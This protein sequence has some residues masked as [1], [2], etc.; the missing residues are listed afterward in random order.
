M[1]AFEAGNAN[2][3]VVGFTLVDAAT[4]TDLFPIRNGELLNQALLPDNLSVRVS[5]SGAAGSVVYA[6]DANSAFQIE[7]NAPYALGGDSPVGDYIPVD[8]PAGPHTIR[9]TPFAGTSGMGAAGGSREVQ[10][11]VFGE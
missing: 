2:V 7:N 8:L 10:L 5:L 1:G 9:A 11:Y 3:F 6:L 4:D